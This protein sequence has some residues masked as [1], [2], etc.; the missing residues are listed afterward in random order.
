MD[1]TISALK[2]TGIIDRWEDNN[3][4]YKIRTREIYS[5]NPGGDFESNESYLRQF[6]INLE[7]IGNG[8]AGLVFVYEIVQVGNTVER[9]LEYVQRAKPGNSKQ[10]ICRSHC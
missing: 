2:E 7:L 1:F 10:R 5:P 3:M 6:L 9:I 8:A 4:N